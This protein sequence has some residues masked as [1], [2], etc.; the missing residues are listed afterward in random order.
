MSKTEKNVIN[1]ATFGAGVIGA[2]AVAEEATRVAKLH[3]L[4][5]PAGVAA[6]GLEHAQAIYDAITEKKGQLP[7]FKE[8]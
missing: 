1:P 4:L 5:G 7:E 8:R 3:E 2:E 6:V